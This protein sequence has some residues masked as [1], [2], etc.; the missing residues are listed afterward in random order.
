MLA[1]FFLAENLAVLGFEGLVLP[2]VLTGDDL[3]LLLDQV[4][5]GVVSLL[6]LCFEIGQ[7]LIKL[8]I[9]RHLHNSTVKWHNVVHEN[10]IEFFR[11]LLA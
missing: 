9:E 10:G 2:L 4:G 7:Q 1:L 6:I 3:E 5:L 11:A 8:C